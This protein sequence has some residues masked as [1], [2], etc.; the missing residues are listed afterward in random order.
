MARLV[1]TADNVFLPEKKTGETLFSHDG[2]AIVQSAHIEPLL[3]PNPTLPEFNDAERNDLE[4]AD[5]GDGNGANLQ[6]VHAA[7]AQE[8]R[9]SP[10]PTKPGRP[11]QYDH[12]EL[13]A[14]IARIIYTDGLPETQAELIR[15]I[16]DLYQQ[17]Y[18][19]EPGTS[20]LKHMVSQ[21]WKAIKD[22]ID[23]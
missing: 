22:D 1:Y 4:Q 2:L 11:Q 19:S 3:G 6:E 20:T 14:E 13:Y 10:P 7:R 15:K 12:H 8:R 17:K 21:I 18:E 23:G 9:I 5:S 16:Q